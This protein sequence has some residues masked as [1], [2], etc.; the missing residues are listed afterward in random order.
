[1]SAL[2]IIVKQELRFL[3]VW[4]ELFWLS[5]TLRPSSDAE[6]FLNRTEYIEL[7]SWK[8]RRLNQLGTPISKGHFRGLY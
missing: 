3:M 2:H 5:D 4:S 1:M 6:L 7:G 8:V